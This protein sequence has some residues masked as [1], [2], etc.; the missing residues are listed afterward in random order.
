MGAGAPM[1]NA[2]QAPTS[3]M[4]GAPTSPMLGAPAYSQGPPNNTTFY[5]AQSQFSGS[6]QTTGASGPPPA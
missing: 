5:S 2:P 6:A 1:M 4:Q 3:P